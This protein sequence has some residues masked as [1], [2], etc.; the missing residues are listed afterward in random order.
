VRRATL[1]AS[2]VGQAFAWLLIGWGVVEFFSHEWVGGIWSVLIGLFLSGAARSGYQ[3]VLIRQALQNEPVTRFMNRDPI[4]VAPTL[5][6]LHWVE[7]FVYHYH[8]RAFPV[9][10]EGRLEGLITTQ[11]LSRIP[12]AE[13]VDHT[14][15]E[16]MATDLGA[17]TISANA[18]AL[19]ALEK[20]Q[21]T[22][23]SRLL[24]TDGERLLGMIGL[25]DVLRF[26]DLKLELEGTEYGSKPVA[27]SPEAPH[28]RVAIHQ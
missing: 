15:G 13:W 3:Q 21:R 11:I 12:R 25:K 23:S 4:V 6:L 16:I 7:D 9:V 18:G 22:G 2:A 8:H 20:M 19:E 24:V 27:S 28:R 26:L 14:V 1:W 5:D 10:N 17:V